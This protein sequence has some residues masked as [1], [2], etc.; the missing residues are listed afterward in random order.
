MAEVHRFPVF[1]GKYE[2]QIDGA[3][4]LVVPAKLRAKLDGRLFLS[5]GKGAYPYLVL[6]PEPSYQRLVDQLNETHFFDEAKQDDIRDTFTDGYEVSVDGQGRLALPAELR[7][8]AHLGSKCM[9]LG[10]F[11]RV[12]IWDREIFQIYRERRGH[13]VS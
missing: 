11:N 7:K 12:E 10:V 9:V 3:N 1:T 13:P 5:L 2:H 6:L 8:S 4:R